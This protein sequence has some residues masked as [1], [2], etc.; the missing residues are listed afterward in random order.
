MIRKA[1]INDVIAIERLEKQTFGSSLG[2]NFLINE[3]EA[4][5]IAHYFVYEINNEIIGYIGVRI[6]DNNAEIF[7]FLIKDSHR[8]QGYGLELFN[9]FINYLNEYNIEKITLEVRKSNKQAMRFYLK[10][11]FIHSHTRKNYYENNEDAYLLIKE[12]EKWLFYQLKVV[13]MKQVLQF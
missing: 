7:N 3:I 12:V 1:T 11:G 9:Y 6:Y 2:F 13:V 8:S 4:N 5:D 10:Q